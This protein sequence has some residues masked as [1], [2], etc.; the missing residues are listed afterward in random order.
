MSCFP[1][2]PC[3]FLR[4]AAPCLRC[5]TFPLCSEPCPG[6]LRQQQL[7]AGC[8]QP[9]PFAATSPCRQKT[10]GEDGPAAE[11]GRVAQCCWS[12]VGGLGLHP[13]LLGLEAPVCACPV[14]RRHRCLPSHP[15]RGGEGP[16]AEEPL[17]CR[18]PLW[19]QM[20]AGACFAPKLLLS[21]AGVNRFSSSRTKG[22]LLIAAPG[23][24]AQEK[25]GSQES[26]RPGG[27]AGAMSGQH[28][29]RLGTP[30]CVGELSW[31]G[32]PGWPL[33]MVAG[34][35]GSRGWGD[36]LAR[37]RVPAPGMRR[38][39]GERRHKPGQSRAPD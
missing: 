29:G 12:R 28:R 4:V 37:C 9:H 27:P 36:P 13:D 30:L 11:P 1:A 32:E 35:A 20:Q 22:F 14:P 16:S 34:Q 38:V 17:A 25:V 10:E 39:G 23:R 24:R 5:K 33:P 26:Q 18:A 21:S 19:A 3:A 8:C 15:C 7:Q 31:A 6:V 2:A